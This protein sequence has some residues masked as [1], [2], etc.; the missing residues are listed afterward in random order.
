MIRFHIAVLWDEI[1]FVRP[2]NVNSYVPIIWPYLMKPIW[3]IVVSN[4]ISS[5][6]TQQ[7]DCKQ[8]L[9]FLCKVTSRITHARERRS[10]GFASL[11]VMVLAAIRNERI[12]REK[13]DCKSSVQY[14]ETSTHDHTPTC[15]IYHY[16]NH[17]IM[18]PVFIVLG[19]GVT[20]CWKLALNQL[21]CKM[22]TKKKSAP[23]SFL[24][25][26]PMKF[27]TCVCE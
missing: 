18:W 14:S 20:V 13:T 15:R 3:E 23:S 26:L 21:F 27:K 17:I 10:R 24:S 7:L 22:Q 1:C 9:T 16:I 11:F 19:Q 2:P 25:T 12:W 8:S 4:T 6:F 5:I